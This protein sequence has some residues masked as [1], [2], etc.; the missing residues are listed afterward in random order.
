M[1]TLNLNDLLAD[2]EKTAGIEKA[3]SVAVKPNITAE[4]SSILEKKASTDLASSAFA[5]GEALAKELLTKLAAEGL[6]Q[7]TTTPAVA[8]NLG[9]AVSPNLIQVNNAETTAKDDTKVIANPGT[10]GSLDNILEGI[11][12]N[13]VQEGAQSDDLVDQV[14]DKKEQTKVA[15]IKTEN[16][17]MAQSIMEKIAQIV[18]EPTTTP[19]AEINLGNAVSPN[20]IQQGN[21][22]IT[23]QDD[24]K[25]LPLPGAEGTL[26]SILEAVVA[27]AE[28]QGA[29]S[30]NLVDGDKPASATER[31]EDDRGEASI[32]QQA[33]NVEKV[34]AVEAL[35]QA[36]CDFDSAVEMVKQAEIDLANEADHQEK[37]AAV[38]A[39][40]EAGYD[41]DSAVALVKQAEV[42]LAN[43]G[44]EIEK[45]AAVQ[46]LMGQGASFEEAVALVKEAGKV[47]EIG[48]KLK[49]VAENVYTHAYVKGDDAAKAVVKGA[50]KV[51][52]GHVVAG[53]VGAAGGAIAGRIS[54]K[55]A[56][57][58]KA[59]F[60]ALLEAGVEFDQAIAMVKQAEYDVYGE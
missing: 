49:D 24:A 33:D 38:S 39:L 17:Q 21:A 54:A 28:E 52:A 10:G 34:A 11:V 15:Q 13:A 23:A 16:L 37:L 14:E 36:G 60:N 45:I 47:G 40:C 57:E 35:V 5:A 4:L 20:L 30:Y 26:N 50:R 48:K 43:E 1:K 32:I 56:H 25:V 46:D 58:K 6:D 41:F 31:P 44:T 42:A 55:K 22:V 59:A 51:T 12:E 19:A 9:N 7:V 8:E 29:A 27:R 18:G 3:A 2:L 53:S